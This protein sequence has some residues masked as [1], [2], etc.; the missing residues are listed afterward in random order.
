MSKPKGIAEQ[1]RDMEAENERLRAENEM[2]LGTIGQASKILSD[3]KVQKRT[4]K[5][6]KAAPKPGSL[7]AKEKQAWY[8]HNN[9]RK[10]QG[11][12]PLSLDEYLKYKEEK[13][14]SKK[15]DPAPKSRIESRSKLTPAERKAKAAF[16]VYNHNRRKKGLDP[17]EFDEY[18]TTVREPRTETPPPM[19]PTY[20]DRA[21]A[22][23]KTEA[24][25]DE[26]LREE[27]AAL[28]KARVKDGRVPIA[29]DT[30]KRDVAMGV[31]RT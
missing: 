13:D 27:L 24:E 1:I 20:V 7:T 17:V 2:L 6:G 9:H 22:K 21:L 26:A 4:L 28:N 18:M 12:G 14:S 30:Y 15:P 3:T 5:G 11:L 25:K 23:A 10:K 16:H 19:A 29:L 31:Y 8:A